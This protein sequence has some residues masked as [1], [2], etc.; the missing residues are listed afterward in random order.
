[1]KKH[2]LCL[3]LF[4]ISACAGKQ[5]LVTIGALTLP[6]RPQA[7]EQ[8]AL[9][10]QLDSSTINDK[11]AIQVSLYYT[12]KDDIY[13][14][15]LPSSDSGS[16]VAVL[17]ALPDS[18]QAFALKFQNRY[19]IAN[20]KY[21]YI[22]PVYGHN[23]KPLAGAH[24]GM[25]LFYLD[26]G[27]NLLNRPADKDSALKLMLKDFVGH[28]EIQHHWMRT[29][30]NTLWDAKGKQVHNEILKKLQ[31]LLSSDSVLSGDYATAYALY[32]K[33]D[34]WHQADSVMNAGLR[35]FPKGEMAM[36]AAASHLAFLQSVDS[37]VGYYQRFKQTFPT[38]DSLSTSARIQDKMLRNIAFRYNDLGDEKKYLVYMSR[39]KDPLQKARDYIFLAANLAKNNS[40]PSLA[41]SIFKIALKLIQTSMNNP[42]QA[43]P[44]YQA[45]K[46]WKEDIQKMY[47][48]FADQYAT[49]LSKEGKLK[50]AV[51][52]RN[53]L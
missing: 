18:A 23:N 32:I 52:Y 31:Q 39:V 2:H 42:G 19:D 33:M 41:D 38:G 47:A 45:D 5:D 9:R 25:S 36:Q 14:K 15:T 12:V 37:M 29:Y 21:N 27:S 24:A 16:V 1:M 34:M 46:D 40:N 7:G 53:K 6:A 3:I 11:Q 44:S 49:L 10:Y 13:V 50:D 43:K 17:F 4:L 51:A 30:L 8:I 22:F 48:P 26:I 28:P 20:E 35:R